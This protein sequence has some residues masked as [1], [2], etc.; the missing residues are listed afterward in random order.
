VFG[1]KLQTHKKNTQYHLIF[2][3]GN[4]LTSEIVSEIKSNKFFQFWLM[5][6]DWEIKDKT[7][8]TYTVINKITLA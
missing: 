2:C 6:M 3:C 1:T 5:D 4:I 8:S 7:G